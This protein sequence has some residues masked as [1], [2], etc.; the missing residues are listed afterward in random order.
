T[1]WINDHANELEDWTDIDAAEQLFANMVDPNTGEP[2]LVSAKHLICTPGNMMT[3]RRVL[4]ATEIRSGDITSGAGNQTISA[5]PVAGAYEIHSSVL[6]YHRLQTQLSLTADQ[7][8][9]HWFLGDL[10]RAF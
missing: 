7:A 4:N 9:K 5:N 10:S 2:I 1:P 8:K 6:A 3:A